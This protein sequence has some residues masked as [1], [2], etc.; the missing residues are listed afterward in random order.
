M[1]VKFLKFGSIGVMNTIFDFVIVYVVGILLQWSFFGFSSA[2]TAQIVS[3]L[4]LVPIS[5]VLNRKWT[6]NSSNNVIITTIAFFA[7]TYFSALFLQTFIIHTVQT[8]GE[9]VGLTSFWMFSHAGFFLM[10]SKAVACAFGMTWNFIAYHFIFKDYSKGSSR[11]RQET[12]EEIR[13][14]EELTYI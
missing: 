8:I 1:I 13:E 10:F 2:V 4:I 11:G 14:K 9:N 3:G 12:P 5:Y 7:S 6:F